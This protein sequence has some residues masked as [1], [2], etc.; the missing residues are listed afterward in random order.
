MGANAFALPGGKIVMTDGIVKAAADK[1]LPDDALVGVL[2]HEIGHVVH[3]HTTRMVLE[4]GVLQMGL[5][6]ALGDVSAIVS[7]GSAL[8]TGLS[9]RRS[10]EREADC[11]AIDL[12]RHAALP[13]AP[14]GQ[15]LLAMAHEDEAQTKK[16]DAPASAADKGKARADAKAHP[17]W[18]LLS[19][20][21]DTIQRATELQQ[22]QA[23][24]CP[25]MH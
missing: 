16:P 22:G 20:H 18:S 25:Q 21:P 17:V 2:A 4:Q 6:L 13:T 24:H 10:H 15:L 23:P 3:R 1:G 7:T 5:G 12:M 14:M 11:Y 19:S 8:L 9:Y